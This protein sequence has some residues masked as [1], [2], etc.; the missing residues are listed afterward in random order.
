MVAGLEKIT[1]GTISIGGRVV[2][3]LES[4]DRGGSGGLSE[5]ALG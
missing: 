2:N 1:S 4:K 5:L 3:E